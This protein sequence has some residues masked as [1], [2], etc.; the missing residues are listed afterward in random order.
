MLRRWLARLQAEPL[1]GRRTEAL[2]GVVSKVREGCSDRIIRF[3]FSHVVVVV[4]P[5][6]QQDLFDTCSRML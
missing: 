3:P 2:M 1:P 6:W 5:I 4:Q